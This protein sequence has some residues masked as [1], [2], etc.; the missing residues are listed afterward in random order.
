VGSEHRGLENQKQ[1]GFFFL[2]VKH[3]M[4][5]NISNKKVKRDLTWGLSKD[6]TLEVLSWV[7][8]C[9]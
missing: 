3:K 9:F 6:T 5:E 4:S 2:C 1:Q 7:S 8:F